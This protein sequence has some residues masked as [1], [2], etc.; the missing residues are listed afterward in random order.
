MAKAFSPHPD[1]A[2]A[3]L[4]PMDKPAFAYTLHVFDKQLAARRR[5]GTRVAH[6]AA[7]LGVE[8]RPIEHDVNFRIGRRYVLDRLSVHHQHRD[9]RFRFETVVSDEF[10]F[11]QIQIK[12][13]AQTFITQVTR[14][15]PGCPL[16]WPA[17]VPWLHR[18]RRDRP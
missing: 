1:D 18:N 13:V 11:R 9:G 4:R 6:L 8:R 3:Q 12:P 5:D 17:A 2:G 16:P 10:G 14:L 15:G 7:A